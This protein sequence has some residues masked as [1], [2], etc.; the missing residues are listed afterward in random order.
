MKLRQGHASPSAAAPINGQLPGEQG[1]DDL[2]EEFGLLLESSGLPRAAGRM[3]AWLLVCDP[4]EQSAED[5]GRALS[6]STGG[7][8]MT[9]RLLVHHGFV[10]RIGRAR[11]RK[12][13]YRV[14]P[15]AWATVLASEQANAARLR[16]LGLRGLALLPD[17]DRLRRQRLVEMTGFCTFLERELP[18]LIQRYHDERD[19]DDE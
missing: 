8:S 6:A 12:V 16:E 18:A 1:L 14:V 15:G 7:V 3:L 4:P 2:L 5:L 10:Q 11:V 17:H 13:Y 19:T 9:V